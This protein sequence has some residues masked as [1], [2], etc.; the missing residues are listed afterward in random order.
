MAISIN[1]WLTAS[2]YAVPTKEN[3]QS[4]E[5]VKE[6]TKYYLQIGRYFLSMSVLTGFGLLLRN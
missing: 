5:E 4:I 2:L 1:G 3:G 6:M